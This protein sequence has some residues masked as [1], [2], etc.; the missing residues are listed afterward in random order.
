MLWLAI[1]HWEVR[2][3]AADVEFVLGGAPGLGHERL[4]TVAELK[5]LKRGFL[6]EWGCST[7]PDRGYPYVVTR[8]QSMPANVYGSGRG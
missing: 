7:V 2:I 6:D 5:I 3:D 4:P 8:L 1:M